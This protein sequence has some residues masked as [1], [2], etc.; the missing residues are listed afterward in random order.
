MANQA[1]ALAFLA[2]QSNCKNLASD[3]VI[4]PSP[5]KIAIGGDMMVAKMKMAAMID[6]MLYAGPNLRLVPDVP[7]PVMRGTQM[8]G[9]RH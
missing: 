7:S 8:R 5:D 4:S 6:A 1:A 2:C 9:Q 3:R